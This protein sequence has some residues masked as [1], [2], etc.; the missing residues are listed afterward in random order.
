MSTTRRPPISTE[1]HRSFLT[2]HV[3]VLEPDQ[4]DLRRAPS[5]VDPIHPVRPVRAANTKT[6][7]LPGGL[8][9]GGSP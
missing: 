6:A 9:E 5:W 7:E 3:A 8:I 2:L 1:M 4:Y